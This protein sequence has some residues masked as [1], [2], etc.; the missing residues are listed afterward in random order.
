LHPNSDGLKRA[1][2]RGYEIISNGID[3]LMERLNLV[4]IV[5]N[6][7]SAHANKHNSDLLTAANKTVI[8]RDLLIKIGQMK[9][10]WWTRRFNL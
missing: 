8:E 4:D 10:V 2:N 7:T 5:Y 9:V 1:K 3:G 6:A